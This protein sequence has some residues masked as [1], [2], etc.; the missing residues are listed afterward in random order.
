MRL[1]YRNIDEWRDGL[2]GKNCILTTGFE[3]ANKLLDL[4]WANVDASVEAHKAMDTG[5]WSPTSARSAAAHSTRRCHSG[6]RGCSG[7][8]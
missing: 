6:R 7:N 1:G 3:I 8:G 4:A 5:H 2:T